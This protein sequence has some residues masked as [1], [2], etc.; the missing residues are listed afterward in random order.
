M[1]RMPMTQETLVAVVRPTPGRTRAAF[2]SLLTSYFGASIVIVKGI[3]LVPLYF[4]TF[5]VDVYGAFL[6]SANVVGLLGVVDFGVSA[7]LYQRLA[8]A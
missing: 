5:G 1:M 4:H 2:L 3:V 7:V 6:A 8:A